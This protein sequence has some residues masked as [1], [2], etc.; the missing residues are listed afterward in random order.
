MKKVIALL[1]LFMSPLFMVAQ[2]EAKEEAE[3][4]AYQMAELTYIKAKVGM[5]KEFV[6]AIWAH[7]AKYHSEAPYRSQLWNIRF[8]DDAGWYV[9]TMGT[10]TFSDLDNAPGQ[11]EHAEDWRKNI[12][13]YV[14]EYGKNETWVLSESA[15]NP[16]PG[17]TK[18]QVVWT[19]DT[20]DG[21]G[22]EFMDFMKQV[23]EV[24]KEGDR[25]ILT[26]NGGFTEDGRDY[27]MV[28][29]MESFTSFDTDKWDI[30]EPFNEKFGEDAWE[31]AMDDW[32]DY[33]EDMTQAL[34]MNVAPPEK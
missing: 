20:K 13:K 29:P 19:V 6:Q 12:A 7:N 27:A 10:M 15:S 26:W 5:E 31:D 28:F 18:I 2:E 25:E 23:A 4:P 32:E 22:D 3:G 16:K 11:G 17:A 33:V 1:C 34:W 14:A 8:G 9:W 21:E 24:H 30:E